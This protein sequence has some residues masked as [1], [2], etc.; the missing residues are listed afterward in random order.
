M[1]GVLIVDDQPVVRQGFRIFLAQHPDI[2]VVGEAASGRAAVERER[3]L[4]PDV[5]LMDLRMPDGDGSP[6]P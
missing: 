4:R 3:R 5:V 2:H 1:V 6:P